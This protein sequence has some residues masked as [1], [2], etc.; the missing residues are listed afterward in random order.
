MRSFPSL[1]LALLGLVVAEPAFADEP[2]SAR[3]PPLLGLP[4]PGRATPD[5][6]TRALE[7]I[8]RARRRTV[9]ACYERSLKR[10]RTL[11]G[12]VLVLVTINP[13]G[14]VARTRVASRRLGGTK[15]AKCIQRAVTKWRFPPFAGRLSK[16]VLLPFA[17]RRR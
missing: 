1:A 5:L 13:N 10:D 2:V 17:L 16:D 9:T 11:S 14:K 6:S 15:V 8:V 4:T 12:R 7:R 3:L